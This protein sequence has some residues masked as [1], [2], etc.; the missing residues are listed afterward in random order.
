MCP[1]ACTPRDSHAHAAEEHRCS[2]QHATSWG[3]NPPV[4][5]PGHSL[6][7]EQGEVLARQ[8]AGHH[9]PAQLQVRG[10]D[11]GPGKH[12]MPGG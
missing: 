2:W 5:R 8:L 4:A 10:P 11:Q 3:S 12:C 6:Q 7:E 1:H 9:G